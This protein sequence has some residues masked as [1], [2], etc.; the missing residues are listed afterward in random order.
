MH[1][2]VHKTSKAPMEFWIIQ[3]LCTIDNH[4]GKTILVDDSYLY[5]GYRSIARI[6]VDL[7]VSRGL[8]ET[9]DLFSKEEILTYAGLC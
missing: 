3:Y 8:F 4:L 5:E 6:L 7:D 1:L 2:G 9:I